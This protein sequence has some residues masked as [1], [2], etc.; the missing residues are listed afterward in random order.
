MV[1]T[2]RKEHNFIEQPW[3]LMIKFLIKHFLQFCLE[4]PGF[5]A[6]AQNYT[7]F[8]MRIVSIL[9]LTNLDQP[10]MVGVNMHN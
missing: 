5:L 4:F 7:L 9:D 10:I 1:P 6:N 3:G 8:L 2:A